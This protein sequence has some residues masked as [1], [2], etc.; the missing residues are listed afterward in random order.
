MSLPQPF[1]TSVPMQTA[2]IARAAFPNGNIYLQM[3]DVLGTIYED[4]LFAAAYSQEGQPALH[5]W[6]LALVTVM[7]FAE[8]LTDR[9]AADAVRAR[10]D[11]KYALNLEITDV[12][13]HYSALCE[14]RAR[15]LQGNLEQ[16]LL[17]RLLTLCA[18]HGWLKQRGRQR[19]DSTHVVGAVKALNII[20]LVGETLRHA[21]NVL[22]VV[23][24]DWLR[25]QVPIAWFE[26]Y[27]E[28][29][30]DYRLP[31]E[32]A[33]RDA[34]SVTYG[35]DGLRLLDLID[36]ADTMPW[37]TEVPA[38][39]TLR[40]VWKQQYRYHDGQVVRLT[41][42]EMIATG[43]WIRSPYDP[44]VRYGKKRDFDWIGYKVHLT[45]ACD[46]EYPHL[47]TQ[48]HTA[49]AMEQDH[50]ALLTIQADLAAKD[51]V[52]GQQLVDAGYV[53]AKRIVHSR[54]VHGIDLLGPVHIDPSWQAR[55]PGALDVSLFTIDWH[56][57]HALC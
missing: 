19:T 38:V 5:P 1:L 31:K 50:H 56:S 10:L 34:L 24:P 28:R 35:E 53:S 20:E 51:R 39:Q 45:E 43:D 36:H 2:L 17:E 12:G 7:Q 8:N 47:I 46:E 9:Q 54:V 25:T 32:Q 3:R 55:T 18:D 41:P 11:W 33:A 16:V 30:E 40:Q 23:V 26:R 29:I 15:L 44:E 52:P 49:P 37:L 57:Q 21:L 48:V 27:G 22:A 6:Q 13:F 4:D 14:F 42:N